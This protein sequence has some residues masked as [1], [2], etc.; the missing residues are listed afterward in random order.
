[1]KTASKCYKVT[2]TRKNGTNNTINVLAKNSDQ[3][4][5]NADHLCFTGSNFR[6]PIEINKNEYKKPLKQ[7]FQGSVRQ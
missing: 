5:K 4:L 7:G 1:M 3:A 6:N 2:Y